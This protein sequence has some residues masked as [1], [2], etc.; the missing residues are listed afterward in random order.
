MYRTHAYPEWRGID[1]HPTDDDPEYVEKAALTL[2][3]IFGENQDLHEPERDAP[4][5]AKPGR[6]QRR[7]RSGRPH[8]GS[9]AILCR[10]CGKT[11]RRQYNIGYNC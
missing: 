6:G 5:A 8:R 9:C 11:S 2:K 1:P 4:R 10:N 3:D 7:S